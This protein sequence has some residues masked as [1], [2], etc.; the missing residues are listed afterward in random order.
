M[1]RFTTCAKLLLAT[2]SIFYIST[3]DTHSLLPILR[4]VD[5]FTTTRLISTK[6]AFRH[7]EKSTHLASANYS[8]RSSGNSKTKS[9]LPKSP[10]PA[11]IRASKTSKVTVTQPKNE[12]SMS[13]DDYMKLPAVQYTCVPM[14][15]NSFLQ[16]VVGTRDNFKLK[17]PPM[18]LQ[19]PG[20][21]LV[22]VKPVVSATVDVQEANEK[23]VIFSDMCEIRGSKIIDDLKINDFF[24][25]TVKVILTWDDQDKSVN[26]NKTG[27]TRD[28]VMDSN[29]SDQERKRSWRVWK[30]KDSE[31]TQLA[32]TS[33]LSSMSRQRL[34]SK[35]STI[36]ASSEISIDLNPPG[37][38]SLVPRS[39]LESVGNR[40]I[41]LTLGALLNPFMESLGKDFEKWASDEHYRTER[42]KLEDDMMKEEGIDDDTR[43]TGYGIRPEETLMAYLNRR[44]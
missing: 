35:A 37:P 19:S 2:I 29:D 39:I 33:T 4:S 28:I 24:D 8:T 44:P 15:M 22:E 3:S 10:N 31:T 13:L 11:R 32:P 6:S 34:S 27:M 18:K 40:A 7:G 9:S 23:V 43:T 5:A 26:G 14:P 20:V 21:P 17:V 25:F 12:S 42:Q 41:S 16:R 30:K 38:F 36:T 1:K